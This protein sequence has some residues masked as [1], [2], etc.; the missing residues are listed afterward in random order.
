ML[1]LRQRILTRL[2]LFPVWPAFA[3]LEGIRVPLRNSP[4]P[5]RLRRHLMGGGYET[6]ERRLVREFVT[7]GDR[8]VELGA[9]AGIMTAFL[10]RQA[11][12]GGRVV[13]VE[14]N[15]AL[16]PFFDRVLAANGFSGEWIG[17]ACFPVWCPA[18]PESFLTRAFV[19][20][21]NPLTGLLGADARGGAP[22]P[23]VLSLQQ[24]C[25]SAALEPTVLVA[26]VEGSEA[27]WADHPPCLPASIRTVVVEVHP[28]IVGERRAAA[29]VQA[30]IRE[31][32]VL[33]G[34]AATVFALCRS[35]Q[36]GPGAAG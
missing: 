1:T 23:P 6:A 3:E 5:P 14:G 32:F 28:G 2:P 31:G 15:A 25:E 29:C 35:R 18:V 33:A 4:F 7:T 21:A 30:L 34:I 9:S 22:G 16:K 10:W 13:S 27:V 24:V 12:P 17:A 8:V 26:D 20:S 11:G 36:P 19:A